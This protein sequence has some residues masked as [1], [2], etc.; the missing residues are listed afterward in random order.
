MHVYMYTLYAIGFIAYYSN[1]CSNHISI[2]LDLFSAEMSINYS[3]VVRVPPW[4]SLSL[5]L[6]LALLLL[7]QQHP[8]TSFI[9]QLF[10]LKGP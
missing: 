3:L 1:V 9:Y 10:F 8:L 2:D 5:S 4:D 7:E 6:S